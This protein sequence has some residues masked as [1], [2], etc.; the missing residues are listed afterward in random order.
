MKAFYMTNSTPVE[1]PRGSVQLDSRVYSTMTAFNVMNPNVVS[2]G[3]DVSINQIARTLVENGISAV[4]VVDESGAP[5][6]MVSEGDLIPRREVE[7]EPRRDWWLDLLAEGEALS[8]D[9]LAN[10]KAT[11]NQKATD[12]MTCP[13]VTV[14]PDI[15]VAEIARLLA[16]HRI[17]RV[18]VVQDGRVV[19]IV[20]R[21]D[22]LR[23]LAELP[24]AQQSASP[25]GFLASAIDS[26]DAHFLATRQPKAATTDV[27]MRDS[28]PSGDHLE[29]ADFRRAVAGFE[30]QE[31]QKQLEH[32][33]AA[34]ER[35]RLKVTELLAQHFSDAQWHDVLRK[36]RDAAE[37]GRKELLLLRFPS[38]LCS[39][40]GRCIN[41][42][43]SNWPATLRGEAA[44]IYMRWQRDLKP[45]EFGLAAQILEFPDGIPG[46]AGLFLVWGT[47]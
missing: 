22:L 28:E 31:R 47:S 10:L 27:Q 12:V 36:A 29:A 1:D 14:H 37:H 33:R 42:S 45:H 11:P 9:F 26:L 15:N 30:Q 34:A 3:P 43:D 18:P 13:V 6:G 7:R 32:T 8:P 4:P 21:A 5:V 41:V 19:G 35:L 40:G 20:S 23:A 16:A 38:Q 39:D 24:D 2:V 17:K 46:D 44:E 25:K